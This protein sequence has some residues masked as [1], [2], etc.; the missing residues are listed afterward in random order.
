MPKLRVNSGT[1]KAANYRIDFVVGRIGQREAAFDRPTAPKR[2]A[3]IEPRHLPSAHAATSL[4][5]AEVALAE[6][7]EN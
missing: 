7:A 4:A 5:R 6:F 3:E 2:R 1:A